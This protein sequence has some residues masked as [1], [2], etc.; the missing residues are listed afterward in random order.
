VID[1][2]FVEVR[3]VVRHPNIEGGIAYVEGVDLVRLLSALPPKFAYCE[4]PTLWRGA[5]SVGHWQ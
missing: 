3:Q 5:Y 4:I 2:I 1:G